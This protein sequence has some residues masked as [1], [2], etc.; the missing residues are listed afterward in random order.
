MSKWGSCTKM[1]GKFFWLG[2]HFWDVFE[3]HFHF[4]GLVFGGSF[5]NWPNLFL[6]DLAPVVLSGDGMNCGLKC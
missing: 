2:A 3:I 4:C 6:V 5:T 1:S